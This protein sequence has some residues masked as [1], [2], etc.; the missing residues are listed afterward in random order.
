MQIGRI[1]IRPSTLTIIIDISAVA[2]ARGASSV[3]LQSIEMA[4]Q[5]T[6]RRRR[7]DE[8]KCLFKLL[9]LLLPP[10]P[11]RADPLLVQW[12]PVPSAPPYYV[13]W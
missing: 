1:I 11:L 13:C 3:Q 8:T 2:A 7:H 12:E 4:T 6:R 10:R 9:L 5:K